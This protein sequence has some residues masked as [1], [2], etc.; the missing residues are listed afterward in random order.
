V[1]E[2]KSFLIRIDRELLDAVQRWANDDL[3]SL[4]GQIEYLLR[5]SLKK[6]KRTPRSKSDSDSPDDGTDDEGGTDGE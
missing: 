1:A 5:R 4:N 2:R 6:A 3:R